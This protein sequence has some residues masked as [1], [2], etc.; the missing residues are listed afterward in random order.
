MVDLGPL[1]RDNGRVL[2]KDAKIELLRRV[3]LFELCSKRELREIAS[4]A[5]ELP[6]PEGRRLAVEGAA[7]HEFMVVVEGTAEVRRK[8]RQVNLLG[9]GDFLGEIA[10]ITGRKRTASVTT[11]EPTRLLVITERDFRRLIRDVPSIQPKVMQALA[12]RLEADD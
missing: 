10:L 5:D 6:L 12:A 3:P 4:I 2:R 9:A 11:L 1:R 7:G 8:G